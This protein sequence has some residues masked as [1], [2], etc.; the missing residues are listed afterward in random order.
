M[1]DFFLFV[2]GHAF[3]ELI[4]ILFFESWLNNKKNVYIFFCI[5][6]HWDFPSIGFLV[7]PPVPSVLYP[8]TLL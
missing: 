8:F 7:P 1:F 5:R 6:I 3:E 2:T 4:D